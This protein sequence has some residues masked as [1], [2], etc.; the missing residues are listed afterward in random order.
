MR[1]KGKKKSLDYTFTSVIL[2]EEFTAVRTDCPWENRILHLNI[3][4]I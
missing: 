4:N 3:A 2:G 1:M